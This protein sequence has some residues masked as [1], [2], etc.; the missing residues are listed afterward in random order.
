MVK[1]AAL[2]VVEIE[3]GRSIVADGR[4]AVSVHRSAL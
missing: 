2:L 4:R 3:S 1:D